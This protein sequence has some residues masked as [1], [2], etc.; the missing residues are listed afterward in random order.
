MA[1]VGFLFLIIALACVWVVFLSQEKSLRRKRTE[2]IR[3]YQR[4][5]GLLDKLEQRHPALMGEDT[6]LISR[7][8]KQFFLAYL[9]GGKKFVAMPSRIVDDLWHEFILY[10]REYEQFCAKAFGRFMHHSPAAAKG[11]AAALKITNGL[12]RAWWFACKDENINPKRANRLPLLFAL[13]GQLQ[14][15][16]G[17]RYDLDCDALQK[18]GVT[19]V[20]CVADLTIVVR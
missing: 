18:N 5:P 12:R 19:G 13:D 6:A 11:P 2:F 17:F 4:P 9:L 3:A 16:N 15:P 1:D 14:I 10:T 7:G 8:L 20:Y